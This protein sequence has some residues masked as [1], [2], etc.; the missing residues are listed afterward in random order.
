M[1]EAEDENTLAPTSSIPDPYDYV[2]N[3]IPQ[4]THVLMP[5]LDCDHCG[6]KK[7]QYETKGFVVGMARSN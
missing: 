5:E 4:S 7:F 2:Y 3:N 6:A 1:E